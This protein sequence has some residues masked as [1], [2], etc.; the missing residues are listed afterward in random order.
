MLPELISNGLASLQQGR[1][2]YTNTAFI[3]FDATGM[4]THA[5]FF[6][7]AIRVSRRF[8]YEDILP[9]VEG[10]ARMCVRPSLATTRR[11]RSPNRF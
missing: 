1:I 2:R 5:E 9:L 10:R 6:R 11:N 3:D 8:A 7:S 4:P